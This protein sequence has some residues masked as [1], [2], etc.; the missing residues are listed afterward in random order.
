MARKPLMTSVYHWYNLW[1]SPSISFTN[2][3][4]TRSAPEAGLHHKTARNDMEFRARGYTILFF[5]R[6]EKKMSRL[7]S[8]FI[9]LGPA[10]DL[11]SHGGERP[12][13][14]VRDLAHPMPAALFEQA[15]E[16]G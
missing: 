5:V 14:M 11:V 12:V 16:G 9:F 13:A 1:F 4:T 10:S 2:N 6:M 7:T 15:R 8:P 3:L